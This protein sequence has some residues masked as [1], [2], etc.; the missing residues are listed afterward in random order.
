MK[1]YSILVIHDARQL[2]RSDIEAPPSIPSDAASHDIAVCNGQ[3]VKDRYGNAD[4]VLQSLQGVR[5][6]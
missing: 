3:I 5:S 1:K 4:D 2:K 6:K